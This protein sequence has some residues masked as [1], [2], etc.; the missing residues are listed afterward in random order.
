MM[1]LGV[2]LVA[3][4][5]GVF[6]LRTILRFWKRK[7]LKNVETS[8]KL[9]NIKEKNIDFLILDRYLPE[10]VFMIA[11][12]K[13]IYLKL[14]PQKILLELTCD[15]IPLKTFFVDK[16]YDIEGIKDFPEIEAPDIETIGDGEMTIRGYFPHKY[17]TF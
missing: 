16:N 11:V 2:A 7:A 4:K 1:E 12:E 8:E 17:R 13:R 6:L 15:S 9:L 5:W 10:V 14:H 3:T